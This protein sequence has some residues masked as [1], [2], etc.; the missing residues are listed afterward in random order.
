MGLSFLLV[1]DTLI[2]MPGNGKKDQQKSKI[3]KR[4]C[5]T[6]N[7][8]KKTTILQG[9]LR[10]DQ[11]NMYRKST[12]EIWQIRSTFLVRLV[13]LRVKIGMKCCSLPLK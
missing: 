3:I 8:W 6:S 7:F 11:I 12:T 1:K 10:I 5:S 9:K 2:Y 4:Q 13:I